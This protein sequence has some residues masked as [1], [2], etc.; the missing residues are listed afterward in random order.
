[1]NVAVWTGLY[2]ELPLSEAL[3][4]L[5]D[6]GWASFEVSTEHLVQGDSDPGAMVDAVLPVVEELKLEIPQAHAYL[7]A[8]VAC[9][10]QATRKEDMKIL[11]RHILMCAELGVKVVVIHPGGKTANPTAFES[12][13]IRRLNIN[14]F[15]T[16][17]DLAGSHDIRIGIEN[18]V[19][20][21]AAQPE[22]IMG[23]LDDID[24]ETIG[25][26]LDTSHANMVGLSIPAAIWTFGSRLIATHISDNDG[27]G[28]QHRTPGSGSIDWPPIAAALRETGYEG[29]FN[30]EIPGERHKILELRALKSRHALDVAKWLNSAIID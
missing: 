25:I 12:A 10:N 6:Q 27:S 13:D 3:R 30:L 23:L 19:R 22:E 4:T 1:M 16:L 8:D 28:D 26:T 14:A 18:L 11:K 20:P 7:Q 9:E 2:A 29:L 24:H 15:R 21:G 5:H 17:G